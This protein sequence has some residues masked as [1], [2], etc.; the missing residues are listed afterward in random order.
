MLSPGATAFS[1]WSGNYDPTSLATQQHNFKAGG[2]G[3]LSY[4][5]RRLIGDT[6]QNHGGSGDLVGW[7]DFA[8]EAP[9][10]NHQ[11]HLPTEARQ[12]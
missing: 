9:G 7:A 1:H 6:F 3:F 12:L 5:F 8:L 11:E 10:N 2:K 4:P